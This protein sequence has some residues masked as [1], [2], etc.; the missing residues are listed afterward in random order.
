MRSFAIASDRP[1]WLGNH[2]T[3]TQPGRLRA[4]RVNHPG[5]SGDFISCEGCSHVRFEAVSD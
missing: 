5:E 1:S 3:R 4:G 2:G